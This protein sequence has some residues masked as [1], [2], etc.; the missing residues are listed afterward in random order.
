M[1][2]FITQQFERAQLE[3]Q[4]RERDLIAQQ[5][6]VQARKRHEEVNLKSNA[7]FVAFILVVVLACTLTAQIGFFL[8]VW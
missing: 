3:E 7:R 6:E 4:K 5:H 1:S 8:K 2:D